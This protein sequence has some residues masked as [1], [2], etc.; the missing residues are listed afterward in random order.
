MSGRFPMTI[1]TAMVSPRARPSPRMIEP[2]MPMRALRSTPVQIISQRVAESQHGFALHARHGGHDLAGER[3]DNG[4]DHDCQNDPSSE[5]P[6][7]EVW[8]GEQARP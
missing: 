1:V 2:T 4:Q 6:N 7:A 8:L 5:H 3:R